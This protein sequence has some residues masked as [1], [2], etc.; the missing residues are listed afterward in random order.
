MNAYAN[1]YPPESFEFGIGVP[2]SSGVSLEP[3]SMLPSHWSSG[4]RGQQPSFGGVYLDTDGAHSSLHQPSPSVNS[5]SPNF[6]FSGVAASLSLATTYASGF[7]APGILYSSAARSSRSTPPSH[8][9][10]TS[11]SNS[12]T[13]SASEGI[14]PEQER[15][16]QSQGPSFDMHSNYT[17]SLRRGLAEGGSDGSHSGYVPGESTYMSDSPSSPIAHRHGQHTAAAENGSASHSTY[18]K[19]RQIAVTTR[20]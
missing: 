5:D 7:D 16:I 2:P 3:V 10:W 1:A 4:A 15:G 9:S 20:H 14:F 18:G 6:S 12:D 17:A 13:Y 11:R 19:G 8:Q